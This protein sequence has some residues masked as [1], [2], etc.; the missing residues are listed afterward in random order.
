[1]G[2][3]TAI[4]VVEESSF[5]SPDELREVFDRLLSIVDAD[6]QLGSLF[7]ASQ[8]RVRFDFT[9][10]DLDLHVAAVVDDAEHCLRWSFARRAPWPPKLSFEMSSGTANAYMQGHD[11]LPILIARGKVR[12]HTDSRAALL[13]L[14]AARLLA[15]PYRDLIAA[16]YP[17][18]LM[19]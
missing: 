4:R 1:M 16:E 11:S 2:A 10:F 13:F 14:P 12:A 6:D 19:V 18:L 15:K 3:A 9:D 5:R 17:H 8:A 7:R